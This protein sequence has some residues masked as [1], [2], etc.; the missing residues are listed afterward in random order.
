ML[1]S[2][3]SSQNMCGNCFIT[4]HCEMSGEIFQT[5]TIYCRPMFSTTTKLP[6]LYQV[7]FMDI[8][9]Q[10]MNKHI[11]KNSLEFYRKVGPVNFSIDKGLRYHLFTNPFLDK[12]CEA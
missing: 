3:L 9:I 10:H 2:R 12:P 8:E 4:R 11:H 5:G 1:L 7:L 6:I